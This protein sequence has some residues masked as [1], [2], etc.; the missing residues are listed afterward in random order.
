M[1]VLQNT[2]L[3]TGVYSASLDRIKGSKS[4]SSQNRSIFWMIWD[5]PLLHV[6]PNG[7]HS[8]HLGSSEEWDLGFSHTNDSAFI[9]R[10]F[11][12]HGF[13]MFP[14][15]TGFHCKHMLLH[16]HFL[17]FLQSVFEYRLKLIW[18]ESE[19]QRKLKL[20]SIKHFLGNPKIHKENCLG[21]FHKENL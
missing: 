1:E 3:K 6:K 16:S 19:V 5:R 4:H 12:K 13:R 21:D 14:N 11:E 9:Q 15:A 8:L 20:I 7:T 10:T 17:K 18:P 2:W